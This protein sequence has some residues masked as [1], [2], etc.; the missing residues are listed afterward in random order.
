MGPIL[1]GSLTVVQL[2]TTRRDIVRIVLPLLSLLWLASGLLATAQEI[3]PIARRLPPPGIEIPAAAR[4]RLEVE[5]T[6]LAA[7]LQRARK[8]LEDE[9][10]E[11]FLP[12]VEV[13]LK[14]PQ[15]AL[16]NDEFYNPG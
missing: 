9:E 3:P 14:A 13:F 10:L 1:A 8:Q 2:A 5:I 4:E 15:Y 11:D 7:D 12:D 6:R 16:E